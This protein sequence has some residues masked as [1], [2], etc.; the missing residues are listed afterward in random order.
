MDFVEDADRWSLLLDASNSS[1]LIVI[2]SMTKFYAIP[3]IRLGYLVAGASL[4][5]A[6]GEL[7]IPWS[8]N[9]LLRLSVKLYWMKQIT[10]DKTMSGSK[11][12]A[13]GLRS[14]CIL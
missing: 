5:Q 9:S 4:V 11:L 7:Q 2:R 12:N 3:G 10:T 13:H 8:V 1:R 6:L 14:N